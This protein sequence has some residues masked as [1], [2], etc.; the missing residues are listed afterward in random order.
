M[1]TATELAM[2]AGYAPLEEDEKTEALRSQIDDVFPG[3]PDETDETDEPDDKD[4][5]DL[6][7]DEL[8]FSSSK[9]SELGAS[10]TSDTSANETD[11]DAPTA[12]LPPADPNFQPTDVGF[13]SEVEEPEEEEVSVGPEKSRPFAHQPL[14]KIAL[15]GAGV[16]ATV[17]AVGGF[18]SISGGSKPTEPVVQASA[19]P[20]TAPTSNP[21]NQSADYKT[22]AA[23][24]DQYASLK[25]QKLKV[26]GAV[27]SPSPTASTTSTT[28]AVPA[29]I[30]TVPSDA[31]VTPPDVSPL[32]EVMP[33]GNLNAIPVAAITPVAPIDP[34]AQWQMIASMGSMGRTQGVTGS[35][36]FVVSYRPD[37]TPVVSKPSTPIAS[38]PTPSPSNLLS[39]LP[40]RSNSPII[41]GSKAS[42]RL[43]SPIVLAGDNSTPFGGDSSS[44]P[45]YLIQLTSSMNDSSGVTV[46]P[47]GSTVVTTVKSFNSGSRLVELQ[48][49]ALVIG[50]KQYTVP[51]GA[52]VIRG[53]RNDSL[54]AQGYGAKGGGFFSKLMPSLFAGISQA[55]QVLNQPAASSTFSSNGTVT[56]TSSGNDR[57]PGAAF[58]SGAFGNLSQQ[59]LA[60]SQTANQEV[61]KG[62]NAFYLNAGASLDLFANSML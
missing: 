50:E 45:K 41:I 6:E 8:G 55:G 51:A 19:A 10:P 3:E 49:V 20:T 26:K 2:M 35:S 37:P 14:P 53:Q 48:V 62:P 44:A 17:C 38:T 30:P 9:F 5:A 12:S 46:I 16:L 24:G 25:G 31:V 52:M 59:L 13:T 27:P 29:S 42:G 28:E 33:T 32:P 40:G 36:R 15:V 47:S 11:E 57:N 58:I 61:A 39:S 23:L 4:D 7:D 54:L 43:V 21:D 1:T 22:E 56:S 34:I 60:N 18:L